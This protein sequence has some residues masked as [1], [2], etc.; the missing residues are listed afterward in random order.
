MRPTLTSLPPSLTSLY[1]IFLRTISASVLH[2]PRS[3]RS[4]RYLYR[5]E[6]E[7]AANV[8][9]KLQAETLDS[10]ERVKLE[11]WLKVW[12]TR[13]TNPRLNHLDLFNLSLF[14]GLD[15]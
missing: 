7:A 5:P 13:S 12:N 8:I 10:N 11:S 1:R 4:I 3:T 9:H 14:S 15:S 6:F 2:Q